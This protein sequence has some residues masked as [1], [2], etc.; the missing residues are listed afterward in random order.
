TPCLGAVDYLG[1]LWAAGSA[2]TS[3]T[4]LA[5]TGNLFTYVSYSVSAMAA[6]PGARLGL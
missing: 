2:G 6:F 4:M 5:G 1:D 3:S